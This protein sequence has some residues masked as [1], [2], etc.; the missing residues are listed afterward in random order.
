MLNKA[1]LIFLKVKTFFI[2]NLYIFLIISLLLNIFLLL[3]GLKVNIVMTQSQRQDMVSS[4]YN[5]NNNQNINM[6]IGYSIISQYAPYFTNEKIDNIL[7][8]INKLNTYQ[9]LF[10]KIYNNYLYYPIID[11]NLNTKLISQSNF[12]TNFNNNIKTN[13][14]FFDWLKNL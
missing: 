11:Y 4:I 2:K 9:Q 3:F 1:K 13:F 14:I 12:S 8:Q 5:V 6:N 10:L 7:Y